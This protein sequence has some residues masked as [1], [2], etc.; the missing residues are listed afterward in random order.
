MA[1]PGYGAQ[2]TQYGGAPGGPRWC[3][4]SRGWWL[5]VSRGSWSWRLWRVPRPTA[6]PTL[7]IL[8]CSGWSRWSEE[9]QRCLTQSGI[10]GTYK[11]FS[12]ETCRL[13]ISMLD[14]D[15]SG[16]MGFPEF[17]ELWT[18]FSN[19]RQNFSSFGPRSEWNC[20]ASGTTTGY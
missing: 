8:R 4:I 16:T 9:L 20:G 17:K 7:R 14:R 6:G 13:M 11:P 1:Y 5:R 2:F 10:S 19:W 18:V 15:M 3:R 12:M